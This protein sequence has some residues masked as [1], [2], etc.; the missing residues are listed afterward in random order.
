MNI[1]LVDDEVAV[2]QIL[3]RAIQW[4]TLGISQVF[5]AY[6]AQ[7]AK[8]IVAEEKVQI[9]ISDI[10]MPQEN[11]LHFL[12]WVQENKPDIVY[13]ILTG[14][15]DFN[16]AK[17]AI[18]I[19]VF[20]FLL[21]PVVFD[22][23]REVVK[24]AIT[25]VTEEKKKEDQRRYGEYYESNRIKAE[26]IFYRE[27]V[28]EEILPFPDYIRNEIRRRGMKEERLELGGM[29]LFRID[30][31]ERTEEKG[32]FLQFALKNIAEELFN[33][34]VMID[35]NKD[36]LWMVKGK[37]SEEELA[38]MCRVYME[39]IKQYL[40]YELFAYL[41]GNLVLEEVSRKYKMLKQAS[42]QYF[43]VNQRI[44]FAEQWFKGIVDEVYSK[45][46]KN[47]RENEII[48]NTVRNYLE[49]HYNE[50]IN[51]K[52]VE[53]L[54]HL[55]QDYLNRV[56]KCATGCTLMEYIQYYRILKAKVFLTDM[57][58]SISEIGGLVGYDSPPYFSKIFK[59][60]TGITPV[61]YRNSLG[62][63]GLKELE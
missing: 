37:K 25:K 49:V 20:K 19:G 14:F 3:K 17:D 1:L 8:R 4:E 60:C 18:S 45:N 27:L 63:D 10:E 2:I 12:T 41:T 13:I 59:K 62:E 32:A 11:G 53:E 34:V 42:I 50:P 16:Y 47:G 24:E 39:K 51:R 26:I 28:S 61:E 30:R 5:T 54:V 44:Y 7:E 58:R 22:E 55:N 43:K 36:I 33:D 38:E 52:D 9:I 31:K 29:I 6:N 57:Q 40:Q 21:K 23:L 48:I 56:F 35:F 46:D 15:P